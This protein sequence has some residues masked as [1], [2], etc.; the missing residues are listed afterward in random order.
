MKD[1]TS[2]SINQA[3]YSLRSRLSKSGAFTYDNIQELESHVRDGYELNREEYSNLKA[4][5]LS[6]ESLGDTDQ[7]I[8]QYYQANRKNI[9]R[10]YFW[11]MVLSVFFWMSILKV[12]SWLHT[13]SI[14]ILQNSLSDGL[15]SFFVIG[16]MLG[17]SSLYIYLLFWI[18]TYSPQIYRRLTKHLLRRPAYVL[19]GLLILISP[20]VFKLSFVSLWGAGNMGF[21]PHWSQG[22]WM[23]SLYLAPA[24]LLLQELKNYLNTDE[25]QLSENLTYK[26]KLSVLAGIFLVFLFNISASLL[27]AGSIILMKVSGLDWPFEVLL[28][29]SLALIYPFWI[30]NIRFAFKHP[31]KFL[32]SIKAILQRKHSSLYVFLI[33][34]IACLIH[35]G[36]NVSLIRFL[37]PQEVGIYSLHQRIAVDLVLVN[38][39]FI[40][41]MVWTYKRA[42]KQ[43][44]IAMS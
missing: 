31:E 33:Y 23:L 22:I 39:L 42:S 20:Y 9:S 18:N 29:I 44:M 36:I 16:F 27:N 25:I 3:L 11:M 6:L 1:N 32:K 8:D 37:S 10:N 35:L 13:S 38:G 15:A 41:L 21:T 24:I 14:I 28:L 26:L 40:L 5:E 43:R 19:F 2:F 7:L 34:G 17:L 4:Y 12:F 30:G